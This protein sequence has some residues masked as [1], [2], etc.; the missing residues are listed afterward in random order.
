M[1]EFRFIELNELSKLN[2]LKEYFE[3]LKETRD[4]LPSLLEVYSILIDNCYDVYSFDGKFLSDN[5]QETE[6]LFI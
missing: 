2:A 4:E 6:A 3:G 5:W 1:K